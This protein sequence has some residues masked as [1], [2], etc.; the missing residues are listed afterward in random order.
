MSA[1]IEQ[2]VEIKAPVQTVFDYVNDFNNLHHWIYG[3]HQITPVDGPLSGLGATY[4]GVLKLG[5][6]LHSRIR[7]TGYETNRLVELSSTDGIENTQRWTFT[8]IGPD[9]TQV[10]VHIDYK[11]P[12]GPAGK[13]IER[14]VKPFVG[15]AV[16][17]SSEALVRNL[18]ALSG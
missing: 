2:R 11:L 9:R 18:E 10:D 17:H 12:G 16:K 14:A 8:P 6:S 7:C 4:D 15:V 3:L 13:A 5:I 1:V